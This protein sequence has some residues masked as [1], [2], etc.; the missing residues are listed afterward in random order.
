M[1]NVIKGPVALS[2]KGCNGR[3]Y[4]FGIASGNRTCDKLRCTSEKAIEDAKKIEWIV[5]ESKIR[6]TSKPKPKE[7]K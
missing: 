6:S 5:P 7:N 2:Y 1:I 4:W 3:R